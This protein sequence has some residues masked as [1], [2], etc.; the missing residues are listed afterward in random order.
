[1][2]LLMLQLIV[3]FCKLNSAD[4]VNFCELSSIESRRIDSHLFRKN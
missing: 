1:M 3:M 2:I 4:K